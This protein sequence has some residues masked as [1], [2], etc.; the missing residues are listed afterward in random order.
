MDEKLLRNKALQMMDKPIYRELGEKCTGCRIC[1][2]V[3]SLYHEKEG[4]NP[5]RSR[6]RVVMSREKTSILPMV[7]R[8]CTD[9]ACVASC[10]QDCLTQDESGMIVVDESACTACG[11]CEIACPFGAIHI[12]PVAD[13]AVTC[14]RC[15]GK[16]LC[17]NYCPEGVLDWLVPEKL[18]AL[19]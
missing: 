8:S 3:C 14:D 12:H 6:I 10:P 11:E 1:E 5:R 7:C 4:I 18:R 16:F 17:V 2:M 15:D 13:V 9:P 19:R